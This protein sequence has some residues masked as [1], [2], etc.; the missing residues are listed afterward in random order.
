MSEKVPDLGYSDPVKTSYVCENPKF[1]SPYYH[2]IG[3]FKG[4]HFGK[5]WDRD[6]QGIPGFLVNKICVGCGK[7]FG[8]FFV[9]DKHEYIMHE[10]K[11][12]STQIM[13]AQDEKQA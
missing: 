11:K 3:L 2:K 9:L 7:E 10:I 4:E 13:V 8:R 6:P 12:D 5:P 1:A